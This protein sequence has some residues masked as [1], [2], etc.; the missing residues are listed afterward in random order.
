VGIATQKSNLRARLIIDQSAKQ[1]QNFFEAT[2]E[3][4]KVV[5]RACGHDD[6]SKFNKY[7]L[8]TMDYTMHRLTGIA[9]AG[10]G[11]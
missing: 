1:L 7:D 9:Y 6:V 3:L 11:D 2:N 5:A 4:I 10:L 8:S